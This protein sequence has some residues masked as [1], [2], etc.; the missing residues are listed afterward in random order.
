MILS[1]LLTPCCQV[2]AL[3]FGA[4]QR[5]ELVN[6]LN[7][8]ERFGG[9]DK[10]TCYSKILKSYIQYVYNDHRVTLI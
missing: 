9:D 5:T 4:L 3:R 7:L 1:S 10:T 2:R 8:L 6:P